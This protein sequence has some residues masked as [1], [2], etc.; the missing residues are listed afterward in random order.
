MKKIFEI[1]YENLQKCAE[2][3]REVFNDKPWNEKWT[4]ETSYIR[5]SD[6]YR[7]PNFIGLMYVENGNV[8]GAVFG[9]C[10]QMYD[11][12]RYFLKEMFVDKNLKGNKIGSEMLAD[13]EKQVKKFD[14]KAVFLFTSRGNH[15]DRF[16]FK[17]K[18]KIYR[19]L[20]NMVMMG[21]T[22]K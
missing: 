8:I 11:G 16:Y 20:D 17:N 14:I 13:I 6:I 2:L 7:T 1:K 3:H 12:K 19:E 10:E 18:Y 4:L 15:T 22:I 9:N 5:L 21:K